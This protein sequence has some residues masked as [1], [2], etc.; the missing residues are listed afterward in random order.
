MRF[1][2]SVSSKRG[3]SIPAIAFPTPEEGV[4]SITL[5]SALE[6]SKAA[7]CPSIEA[8]A[9]RRPVTQCSCPIN[10]ASNEI[11]HFFESHRNVCIFVAIASSSPSSI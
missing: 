11:L 6:D 3:K 1:F 8:G 10:K 5:L 2:V 7:G 4:Q 9:Q